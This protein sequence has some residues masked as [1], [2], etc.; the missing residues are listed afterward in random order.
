MRDQALPM[1]Y[2]LKCSYGLSFSWQCPQTTEPCAW[3][4]GMA[5]GFG[6]L[7]SCLSTLQPDF[8]PHD[9]K[10]WSRCHPDHPGLRSGTRCHQRSDLG[11]STPGVQARLDH[12]SRVGT[13]TSVTKAKYSGVLHTTDQ[14]APCGSIPS[15]LEGN[16]QPMM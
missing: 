11:G 16:G 9:N 12:G 7:T 6:C 8:C 4:Q 13:T 2:S 10:I 14:P 1:H 3:I 15:L 5:C